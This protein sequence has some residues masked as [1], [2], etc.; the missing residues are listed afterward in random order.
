[1]ENKVVWELRDMSGGDTQKSDNSAVV[2]A[3]IDS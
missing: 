1:M 3:S 2:M